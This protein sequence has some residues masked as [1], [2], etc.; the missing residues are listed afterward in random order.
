MSKE[1]EAFVAWY[2]SNPEQDEK[3]NYVGAFTQA[4]WETWQDCANTKNTHYQPLLAVKDAEIVRLR[5]AL[6]DRAERFVE[7][8]KE[9]T[10]LKAQLEAKDAELLAFIAHSAKNADALRAENTTLKALLEQA[11]LGIEKAVK[12]A[13]EEKPEWY[14]TDNHGDTAE[15]A[16]NQC[17]WHIASVLRPIIAAI[18]AATGKGE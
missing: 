12:G 18:N 17:L 6:T 2:G 14:E 1:R 15:Q 11:R 7:L 3:G 4:R 8:R 16:A 13:P 9:N 5:D 10:A